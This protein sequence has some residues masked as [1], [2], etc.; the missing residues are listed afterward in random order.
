MLVK[1]LKEQHM[2]LRI[3]AIL[4]A[5]TETIGKGNGDGLCYGGAI[6]IAQHSGHNAKHKDIVATLTL[7]GTFTGFN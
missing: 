3:L 1:N 4:H 7:Y 5:Q 2:V 6:T